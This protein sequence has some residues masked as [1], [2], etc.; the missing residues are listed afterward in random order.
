M[1]AVACVNPY[2]VASVVVPISPTELEKIPSYLISE[3]AN[4]PQLVNPLRTVVTYMRQGNIY[5]TMCKQIIITS[6]AF[7]L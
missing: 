4:S 7:T 3:L 5:F 2:D 6:P 1:T